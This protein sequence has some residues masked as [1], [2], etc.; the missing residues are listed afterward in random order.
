MI[1]KAPSSTSPISAE[2][3]LQLHKMP[4]AGWIRSILLPSCSH[5]CCCLWRCPPL[6]L[7]GT[8]SFLHLWLTADICRLWHSL[9]PTFPCQFP[10][11]S[12]HHH[13]FLVPLWLLTFSE[14]EKRHLEFIMTYNIRLPFS[15]PEL[16]HCGFESFFFRSNKGEKSPFFPI[17]LLRLFFFFFW[18]CH[19]T[20]E[21]QGLSSLT[22]FCVL[23]SGCTEP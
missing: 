4:D 12:V 19:I 14:S 22:G 8:P 16:V 1:S 5:L 17:N 10:P 18:L 3:I 2:L 23:S 9:V 15:T 20:C 13:D 6:L 7:E 21:M 11:C